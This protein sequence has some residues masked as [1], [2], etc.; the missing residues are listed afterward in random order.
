MNGMPTELNLKWQEEMRA[1]LADLKRERVSRPGRRAAV[2]CLFTTIADKPSIL[3]TKRTEK[4][5]THKGQVSFPGGMTDPEDT[6]AVATALRE[7]E[8]E[9]G[10]SQNEVDVLGVFHDAIAITGVPVTPVIGY[11]PKCPDLD[12][13][14]VS[15]DEI[16]AVFALSLDEF[17]QQDK[18]STYY[19]KT[20]ELNIPVFNAGPWPVW[21]LT[22]YIANRIF[23][24]MSWVDLTE[25][26]AQHVSEK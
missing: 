1:R 2:L 15:K 19:Y 9:L 12:S 11:L 21:G 10:I 8:E 22:A 18:M 25:Q 24:V 7:F 6:D 5:G 23:Q 16:D 17:T 4:V 13:L 20:R 26:V 14:D 3:F